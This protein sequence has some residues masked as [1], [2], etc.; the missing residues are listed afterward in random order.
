M[1]C[2]TEAVL[3]RSQRADDHG[4]LWAT[5]IAVKRLCIFAIGIALGL[6]GYFAVQYYFEVRW[7]GRGTVALLWPVL[8]VLYATCYPLGQVLA[9]RFGAA[10]KPSSMTRCLWRLC[11]IGV[12]VLV[13]MLAIFNPVPRDNLGSSR[14]GGYQ[15]DRKRNQDVHRSLRRASGRRF[16]HRLPGGNGIRRTVLLA[17]ESP[18]PAN[19]RSRAHRRAFLKLFAEAPGDELDRRRQLVCVLHLP[20]RKVSDLRA[21]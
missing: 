7:D 13:S 11:T 10:S 15:G 4:A 14:H 18:A 20:G 16:R 9:T 12:V 5:L 6:S 1:P 3:S 19:Q 2:R 17:P 21:G 8:I